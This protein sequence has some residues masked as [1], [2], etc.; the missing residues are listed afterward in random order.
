[1]DDLFPPDSQPNKDFQ[2][3]Q[4]I[5]VQLQ[6]MSHETR[7]MNVFVLKYQIYFYIRGTMEVKEM[8]IQNTVR[9]KIF[10]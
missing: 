4:F 9:F 5:R 7:R 3:A 10:Q 6:Y 1:M 2:G 8:K